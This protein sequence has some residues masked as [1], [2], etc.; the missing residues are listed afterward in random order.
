[1]RPHYSGWG[2]TNSDEHFPRRGL[3]G[4][5]SEQVLLV[6]VAQVWADTS[7][8]LELTLSINT[9]RRRRNGGEFRMFRRESGCR[10]CL[11][12]TVDRRNRK[13][14]ELSNKD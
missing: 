7:S 1:L 3:P 10:R 12:V 13:L 14:K 11:V 4:I 8:I 2:V 9:A 6:K 5:I